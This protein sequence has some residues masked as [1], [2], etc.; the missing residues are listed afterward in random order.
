MTLRAVERRTTHESHAAPPAR[1][2][3]GLHSEVTVEEVGDDFVGFAGFRQVRI[4]EKTVGHTVPDKNSGV[5]TQQGKV[6]LGADS[7]AQLNRTGAG[8]EQRGGNC[9]RTAR[10]ADG[11]ARGSIRRC[12]LSGLA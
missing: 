2:G 10:Q 4:V 3:C 12:R 5:D 6:D 9:A 1:I 11:I 7:A 8:Y